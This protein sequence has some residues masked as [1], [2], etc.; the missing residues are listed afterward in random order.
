M[1]LGG[2]HACRRLVE[3][4]QPGLG[5]QRDPDFEI[6][7][8]AVRQVGRQ[9]V[10]LARKTNR[11]QHLLGLLDDVA[12]AAVV[13]QH[14]PTVAPRLRGD[15]DIL[16]GGGVGKEVGDLIRSGDAPMRDPIGREPG[17]FAAVEQDM[18]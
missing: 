1:G 6:A 2:T 11:L 14:A 15:P 10:R 3:A 16:E 13:G 17:D 4:Q 9:L 8:L 5:R 12:I 7:L 18:P